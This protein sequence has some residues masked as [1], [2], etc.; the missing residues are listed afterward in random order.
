MFFHRI[1]KKHWSKSQK[2]TTLM[3]QIDKIYYY[4]DIPWK[5]ELILARLFLIIGIRK[6]LWWLLVYYHGY[7]WYE[8]I[9]YDVS[10]GRGILLRNWALDRFTF[11]TLYSLCT[12]VYREFMHIENVTIIDIVY[13]IQGINYNKEENFRSNI[14]KRRN[15]FVCIQY[16]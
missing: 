15:L 13:N 14:H 9:L 7:F 10:G 1:K 5:L 3:Y 8:N 16:T 2:M 12:I 4:L 11:F 6:Y